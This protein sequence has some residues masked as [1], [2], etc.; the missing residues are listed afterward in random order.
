MKFTFATK[1]KAN[2][3]IPVVRADISKK[4][5]FL[6]DEKLGV[7]NIPQIYVFYDGHYYMYDAGLDQPKKFL[8]FM[9]RLLHPVVNLKT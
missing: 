6:T 3:R 9:N 1:K 8:H 5:N 7:T 4:L 2:I